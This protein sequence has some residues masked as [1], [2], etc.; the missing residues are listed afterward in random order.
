VVA[1]SNKTLW[2]DC[3][4]CHGDRNHEILCKFNEDGSNEYHVTMSYLTIRCLGCHLI[5]F[6]EEVDD[7]EQGGP[8]P[9]NGETWV[10]YTTVSLYPKAIKGHHNLVEG[11]LL[12]ELVKRI[13]DQ[14]L[15]SIRENAGILGGLG[16][17]AT[18]EAVCNNLNISGANLE[19]R[20]TALASQGLISKKDA[21]RLHAIRFLGNDAAHDIKEPNKG[22]LS[23]ALKI[24]EHLLN[25]VYILEAEAADQL[26]TIVSNFEGLSQILQQTLKHFHSGDEQ[27]LAKLLGKEY[28]RVKDSLST[29]ESELIYKITA[30]SFQK[31]EV[32][33]I[34]QVGQPPKPL[35]LFK[36]I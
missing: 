23:V 28:R 33:Q 2:S 5:S 11:W 21:E 8:D 24:V 22:Q 34:L 3:A 16:L 19:R 27:P 20:I 6:R 26:D 32:G 4:R 18:I 30:S 35:Q 15:L 12:P 10:P 7:Y 13:Y 31:L 36:V 14:T 9:E 17:R 25:T 29:L 1:T